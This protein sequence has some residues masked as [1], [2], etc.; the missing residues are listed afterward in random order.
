MK[1]KLYKAN[2][3]FLDSGRKATDIFYIRA[4]N[5]LHARMKFKRRV[6]AIMRFKCLKISNVR[7]C[8]N[9]PRWLT[10]EPDD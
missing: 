5:S 8:L 4:R 6:N 1:I 7:I 2:I 9:A 3:L 10:D